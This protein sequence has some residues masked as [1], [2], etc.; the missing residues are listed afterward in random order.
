MNYSEILHALQGA[1]L[2]DLYR[3]RVGIDGMLD[4][5]ERLLPVTSPRHGDLL[6]QRQG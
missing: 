4:Q 5:P 2:F 1:S 6:F 3:L